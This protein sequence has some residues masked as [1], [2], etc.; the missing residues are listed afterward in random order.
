MK[1]QSIKLWVS[2]LFTLLLMVGCTTTFTTLTPAGSGT[3]ERTFALTEAQV[4]VGADQSCLDLRL[5]PLFTA[6]TEVSGTQT[7]CIQTALFTDMDGLRQIYQTIPGMTINTVEMQNG[8]VVHD[9]TLTPP[10][11]P[12]DQATTLWGIQMPGPLGL[13]NASKVD[14]T[15]LWWE[16]DNGCNNNRLQA[17]S[18]VEEFVNSLYLPLIA[19]SLA[20]N[21]ASLPMPTLEISSTRDIGILSSPPSVGARDVGASVLVGRCILWLFGDTLFNPQSVDGT[22]GRSSTAGLADPNSPFSLFEKLDANGAPYDFL[23]FTEEEKNYNQNPDYPNT[24][25]ALWVESAVDAG[26]GSA[27]IFYSKVKVGPDPFEYTAVGTGIARVTA[28]STVAERD[29]ELLFN[30]AEIPFSSAFVHDDHAYLY[31]CKQ[32]KVLHSS[33]YVAR[34]LL[35]AARNRSAYEFWNGTTWVTEINQATEVFSGAWSGLTVSWNPYFDKFLLVHSP[36]DSNDVLMRTAPT[37]EG[38][39]SEPI[40][41]FTGMEPPIADNKN[42]TAREHPELSSNDGRTVLIT[43]YHPL[44]TTAEIRLVEVTFR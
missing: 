3:V 17:E 40:V 44:T 22:N 4:Q 9:I 41:A 25:Y 42:Y 37:P 7:N 29:A 5:D 38:P 1:P 20:V 16:T 33:C 14:T 26:D 35:A 23:I 24:R 43:Y 27:L 30:E 39:W 6:R 36:L 31:G 21:H 15:T 2:A 34:A 28:G 32:T 8:Q 18:T 19:S 12:T 11:T 10:L 13:H